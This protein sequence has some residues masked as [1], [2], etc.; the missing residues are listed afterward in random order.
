ML[1]LTLPVISWA[2]RIPAWIKLAFLV[3]ISFAMF[4]VRDITILLSIVGIVS[5]LYL[6]LGAMACAQGLKMLKPLAWMMAILLIYHVLTGQTGEGVR[7]TLK[8][9]ALVGLANFVTMT[10][11]LDDMIGVVM[12]LLSPLKMLGINTRSIALAFAMVIR[13][14]P[15]LFQKSSDIAMSWR[16]RSPKR[17]GWRVVLPLC[18]VAIDDAEHISEA[19]RARGGVTSHH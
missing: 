16:A 13:F 15:V 11:R 7:I 3:V 1:S 2:H 9:F 4:P 10:T 12:V 8:M 19:L 17:V 14:T 18:F 6:T 5:S